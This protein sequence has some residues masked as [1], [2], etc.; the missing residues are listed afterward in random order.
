MSDNHS[1]YGM[2]GPSFSEFVEVVAAYS[3]VLQINLH[4]DL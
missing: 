1:N 4:A 3:I 2:F